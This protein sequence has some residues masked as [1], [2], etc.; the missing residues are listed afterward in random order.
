[1]PTWETTDEVWDAMIDVNLAGVFNLA[2]TVVPHLL[3]APLPRRGRFVAVTSAAGHHGLPN[4]A[5]YTAAKHG[6][7][8]LVR[9]LAAELG[10]TGVTANAV[11][12]GSTRG[13][14]LEASA[15]LYGIDDVE[16]FAELS[17]IQRL[18]DPDEIAAT[19]EWLS[20]DAPGSITGTVVDV[21]GGFRG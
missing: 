6:V 5:A 11:A 4:L 14:M 18:I 7:V 17:R 12:P 1:V 13:P 9:A 2:R 10:A 19:I 15:A 20:V 8:G 21:D 3:A 16:T